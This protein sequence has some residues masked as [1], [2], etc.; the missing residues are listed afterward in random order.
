[1]QFRSTTVLVLR[2]LRKSAVGEAAG[3]GRGTGRAMGAPSV[4]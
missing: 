4:A 2:Q 1:M 3:A